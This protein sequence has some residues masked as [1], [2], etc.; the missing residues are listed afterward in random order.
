MKAAEAD[1][2]ASSEG[3]EDDAEVGVMGVE[4]ECWSEGGVYMR[5]ELDWERLDPVDA[6]DDRDGI[7]LSGLLTMWDLTSS[8]ARLRTRTAESFS[9]SALMPLIS[10]SSRVSLG[11]LK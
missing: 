10:D 4:A 5:L 3:R 6:V 7:P 11:L 2:A 8:D 1:V 9:A